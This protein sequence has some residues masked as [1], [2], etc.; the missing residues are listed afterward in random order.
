LVY[1]L[2]SYRLVRKYQNCLN[3][4]LSYSQNFNFKWLSTFIIFILVFFGVFSISSIIISKASY[5]E[6]AGQITV[7]VFYL[8]IFYKTITY[9]SIYLKSIEILNN[10]H[11]QKTTG[12]KHMV[13]DFDF[14]SINN[15]VI[16]YMELYKP[17]LIPKLNIEDL[18]KKTGIKKHVLSQVINRQSGQNFYTFINTYRVDEA[19][20]KL[21][22]PAFSNLTIEAIGKECGFYTASNFF[23][24]FKKITKTTP[25][26]YRNQN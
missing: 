21:K 25:T 15:S 13:K 22:D 11:V 17:Y 19:K 2:V 18:A 4:N 14:A 24:V 26:K 3:Q 9:P 20:K 5:N 6:W 16:K 8:F 23:D 10:C 12:E 1:L 7:T